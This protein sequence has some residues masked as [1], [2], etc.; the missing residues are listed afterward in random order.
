MKQRLTTTLLMRLKRDAKTSGR[1]IECYDTKEPSLVV[2]VRPTGRS[3][4]YQYTEGN[5]IKRKLDADDIDTAR[6]KAS[7]AGPTKRPI[8]WAELVDDHYTPSYL[9]THKTERSLEAM[10]TFTQTFGD[11]LITRITTADIERWIKA[12]IDLGRSLKT[13]RR[14]LAG[15]RAV[16]AFAIDRGYLT[17]SPTTKLGKISVDDDERERYLADD[18]AQR[19]RDALQ[20]R[21][22][23]LKA[24]RG[25]YNAH[26]EARHKAPLLDLSNFAFGDHLTPMVR[27]AMNTGMRFGELTGIEWRDVVGDMLTVRSNITKSR[28]TRHVPLNTAA[29]DA[30]EQW[31]AMSTSTEGRIFPVESVRKAWLAVLDDAGITD[32]RWHDLRHHF[33]STLVMAGV[34][35][36]TV[37]KLLGH[38]SIKMTERY[39][40]LA[41]GHLRDAVGRMK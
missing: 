34:D 20:R 12:R 10:V 19:L 7:M 37:Q 18:E 14:N 32:F 15:V 39:S 4:F 25:R 28:K 8:T 2:R 26:R 9:L 13:I 23:R 3:S 11:K 6:A 21:D 38:Q 5:A 31:S 16:F 33:A 24:S 41:P 40:H 1:E 27:I 36:R 22:D 17:E 30:L 35:L 29:E